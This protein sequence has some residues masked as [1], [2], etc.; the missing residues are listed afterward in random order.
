VF[1]AEFRQEFALAV[2]GLDYCVDRC[3]KLLDILK[4]FDGIC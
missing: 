1:Q 2:L 3:M 4:D